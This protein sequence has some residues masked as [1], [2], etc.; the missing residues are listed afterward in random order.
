VEWRVD[1]EYLWKAGAYPAF[2]VLS[3]TSRSEAR[4]RHSLP[5][6]IP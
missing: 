3:Q 1:G 2:F 4:N 6:W 5:T